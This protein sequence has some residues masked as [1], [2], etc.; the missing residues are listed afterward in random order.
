MDLRFRAGGMG[1]LALSA[2]L[3]IACARQ[4]A[5]PERGWHPFLPGADAFGSQSGFDLRT[6][7]EAFAGENGRILARDG[8]FIHEKSGK[9]VRF[10]AV[11]GP[12]ESIKEPGELRRAA[13]FLAKY[14]VNLVRIHHGYFDE[15]GAV[16]PARVQQTLEVVDAMKEAGIY[17]HLSIYFPLWI[18]PKPGTPWLDGYDGRKHPFAALFF[19]ADFQNQYRAWWKALL[20]TPSARTGRRL[21]DEPA[22]MGAEL[23]NEDSFFF[24][25]FSEQNIPDPQLRMLERQFGDW[26][27]R[28]HGSVEAALRHWGGARMPRDNPSAGR[29][30]FRPLWA[31][32][33]EKTPRDQ[34]TA[35]FLLETQRRFY[36]ETYAYLRRLGFKGLITCSNWTTASPEVLG[37]LEK[38]TY[39]EGDFMDRHGYFDCSPKG[40]FSEWSI[41]DGQTYLDRSALRFD[42]PESGK[43]RLFAHPAMDPHYAG[44][45]SMISETT[46]TRPNRFR[47]EAPLFLASYGALQDSDAIV[48]FAFDGARWEVKPNFWMQPWTLC[49]PAMLGQ[50]PAAALIYR[51]GLVAPGD[52]L[53]DLSLRVEDLLALKGTPLP[54]DA[55]LDELRMKD[56][57]LAP[58][59][60]RRPGLIDPLIHF[61][62]RTRVR[63]A[64]GPSRVADLRPFVDRAGQKVRSTHGQLRLDYGRGALVIDAPAAQGASGNLAALGTVRTADLTISSSMDLG[65]VVAVSL[66][67]RPLEKSGRILLQVMSEEQNTGF[68]T[69]AAERGRRRIRS[70]GRDPW[71]VRAMEGVVRFRRADASRLRVTALDH[72]GRPAGDAGT[73]AEIRLRPATL[74]YLLRSGG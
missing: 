40:E 13:R 3:L 58:P 48:H 33:N 9:S 63:F 10:W 43:P 18:R 21:I 46:W 15:D 42:P 71:Q 67:G 7:N 22:V 50:F 30:A 52:V 72:G 11:N 60:G 68:A 49:S 6:L 28:R 25:T 20:T 36:R 1:L 53:A 62:G 14:G 39:T 12:P 61:A 34:E 54:Q 44:L 57:P 26:L 73:A 19:N 38:L 65:H 23:Q 45:P 16:V 74:Y 59:G 8:R 55:A 4:A 56:V 51:Q 2:L 17:T 27:A 66:D 37:P 70:I 41:R 32:F 5:A 31:M 69:E 24:W 29:A 64:D 35:A 47:S